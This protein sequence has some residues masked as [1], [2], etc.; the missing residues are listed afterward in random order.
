[1]YKQGVKCSRNKVFF[2]R[3]RYATLKT[4]LLPLEKNGIKGNITLS[5]KFWGYNEITSN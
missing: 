2:L 4:S 3:K 5:E 1:M